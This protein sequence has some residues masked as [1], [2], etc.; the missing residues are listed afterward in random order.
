MNIGE[1]LS[2]PTVY[3]TLFVSGFL[4][5]GIGALLE[6]I[7]LTSLSV[8]VVILSKY[9]MRKEHKM[10]LRNEGYTAEKNQSNSKV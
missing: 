1:R 6:N 10:K 5:L 4:I 3:R 9:G 2:N 7:I 8:L